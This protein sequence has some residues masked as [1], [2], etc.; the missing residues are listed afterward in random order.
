[1]YEQ[2]LT[3]E[4]SLYVFL[5]DDLDAVSPG[6]VPGPHVAVA[7]GDGST[8]GQVPEHCHHHYNSYFKLYN[9]LLSSTLDYTITKKLIAL[10]H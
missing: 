6:P 3:T 10:S 5:P 2:S 4:L 8:H 7:L 1:M 9:D